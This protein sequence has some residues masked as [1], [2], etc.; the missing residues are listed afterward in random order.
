M[1]ITR[2]KQPGPQKV[3]VYGPEGIGK[4]TFAAQFPNPLF[5]DTE[6]STKHLD[7]A[8]FPKPTS[9]AMLMEQAKHV[10]KNPDICKTYVVD[11]ADWAEH[12]CIAEICAKSQKDGIEAFGYGKGYTYLEEE[13][14]RYLNLLNEVIERGINVVLTAHAQIKKFD[15]PDEMGS[16]DRWEMKLQKKTTPLVKEWADMVLFANYKTIVVNVDGQGADKGKNKAQGGRR[17]MYTSHHSC[18]DAKNRHGLPDELD[19]A[20]KEIA[21]CITQPEAMEAPAPQETA[22]PPHNEPA[23]APADVQP[24]QMQMTRD[25]GT[26]PD[27]AQPTPPPKPAPSGDTPRALIDLMRSHDVSEREI[28]QAVTSR[29]YYPAGTPIANYDPQFIAGVLVGAWP[30]VFEMIKENRA[31]ASSDFTVIDDSEDLPF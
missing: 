3:I 26:E 7:V 23:P 8:R 29:G 20:Y 21:K 14:G 9:W 27:P 1:E 30:Q 12:L 24:A 25:G 18:W 4:S 10:A 28:R 2:G 11:T 31:A 17:V 15:Q 5:S 19:F 22:A 13:F 6:G 16:Y